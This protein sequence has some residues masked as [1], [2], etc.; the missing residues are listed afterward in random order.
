MVDGIARLNAARFGE[1]T[2]RAMFGVFREVAT[3][4]TAKGDLDLGSGSD[5][6]VE[7]ETVE[8]ETFACT[9]LAGLETD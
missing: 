3:R 7:F 2:S 5:E 4:F 8:F 1:A 6:A 9:A